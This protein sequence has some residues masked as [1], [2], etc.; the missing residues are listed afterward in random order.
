MGTE[1]SY[2]EGNRIIDKFMGEAQGT[3]YEIFGPNDY[4]L[5]WNKLIEAVETIEGIKDEYHGHFGIYIGSNSCSIQSTKFRS[6][7][8]IPEPPYYFA[9]W[10]LESKIESTWTAVVYFINWYMQTREK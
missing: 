2:E 7:Q 6:D 9:S 4:G 3:S 8:I 1:I 10:T 5:D